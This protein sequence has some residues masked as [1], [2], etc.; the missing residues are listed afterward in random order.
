MLTDVKQNLDL[1]KEQHNI[2][3]KQSLLREISLPE[4]D[5]RIYQ[6]DF[7]SETNSANKLLIPKR[8]I[9]KKNPSSMALINHSHIFVKER[10]PR[11]T[12]PRSKGSNSGL[13]TAQRNFRNI[14][15]PTAS[16]SPII[17]SR[18]IKRITPEK[19]S[20]I[21]EHKDVYERILKKIVYSRPDSSSQKPLTRRR[22]KS[23]GLSSDLRCGMRLQRSYR[24]PF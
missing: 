6:R 10:E 7:D 13:F 4:Q 5:L 8:S 18:S 15:L 24:S 14:K 16:K 20:W 3:N 2:L 12:S 19:S 21:S 22:P 23:K 1:E 11:S 9:T 17:Q